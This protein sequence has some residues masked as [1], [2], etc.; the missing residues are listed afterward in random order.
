MIPCFIVLT[1]GVSAG[2]QAPLLAG[3]LPLQINLVQEA[4]NATGTTQLLAFA[5]TGSVIIELLTLEPTPA[6]TLFYSM[7]IKITSATQSNAT[8]TSDGHSY[9]EAGSQLSSRFEYSPTTGTINTT[10]VAI[11][12]GSTLLSDDQQAAVGAKRLH[13][14]VA[15]SL[16]DFQ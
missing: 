3:E 10:S 1:A 4:K 16:L 5:V 6:G 12:N 9:F 2:L 8:A 15:T 7:T 11:Y 14:Q 13:A